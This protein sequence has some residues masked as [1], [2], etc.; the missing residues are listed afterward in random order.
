MMRR[1][2]RFGF[3]LVE[4]LVVIAIIGILIA[5]LLPAVQAAREAAR[6]SQCVNNLKQCGVGLHNYNDTMKVLPPHAFYGGTY[7]ARGHRGSLLVHLLPYIEQQAL[8]DLFDFAPVPPTPTDMNSQRAPT[9]FKDGNTL[10]RSATV[11]T[12]LCP[13]DGTAYRKIG[14]IPNQAQTGSYWGCMGPSNSYSNSPSCSCPEYSLW[15]SYSR[16]GTGASNPAG[17]FTRNGWD[18]CARFSDVRDGLSNT[19]FM[20]EVRADCSGHVR[21]GWSHSNRWG[22]YTQTP[23]NYDSCYANLAEA[24]A[25]GGNGCNAL[26]NWNTEVGFKS[27]HPGGANFLFGDGSVHFLPETIDHWTYQ[28]LGDKDDGEPVT[29]P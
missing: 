18:Y 11:A 20:G 3:T 4:L 12:Y 7:P 22:I 17:M 29:I 26:C 6:R 19:I 27:L 25:A 24:T 9:P 21:Q 16:S 8:Y 14:T 5:L 23:I 28:Y 1:P 2:S 15:K 13:S 10:L